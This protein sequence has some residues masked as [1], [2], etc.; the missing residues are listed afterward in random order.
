MFAGQQLKELIGGHGAE[1]GGVPVG[2]DA[3]GHVL[4]GESLGVVDQL[5]GSAPLADAVSQ[6]GH[7]QRS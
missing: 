1:F 3:D 5:A 6:I 4:A 2:D 7:S